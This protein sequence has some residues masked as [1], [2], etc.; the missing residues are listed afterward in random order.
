[1]IGK[2]IQAVRGAAREE[3]YRK[4][5]PPGDSHAEKEWKT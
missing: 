1:M 2:A 5:M 4:R 3:R